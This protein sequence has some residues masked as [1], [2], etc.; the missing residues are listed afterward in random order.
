MAAFLGDGVAMNRE[1]A[2]ELM[3]LLGATREREGRSAAAPTHTKQI[4]KSVYV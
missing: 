4:F 1:E 2:F 3:I